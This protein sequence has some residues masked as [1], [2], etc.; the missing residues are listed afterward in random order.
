MFELPL[1]EKI[2]FICVVVIYLAATVIGILQLL[3]GGEKYKRSL[4]P[5][6]SL[7]LTLEAVIL[8]FRAVAI[9]AVPLTGL[10]ESMIVLTIVL[11]LTYLFFS[12]AIQQVWFGSVMVWV[13]LVLVLMAGIVAEPASEPHEIAATPWAIVHGITMILGGASTMFATASSFLYLLGNRRLKHKKV[14]KVIG[15]VPNIEKLERMTLFGIRAGFVLITIGLI[16]GLGLVSVVGTGILKWLMDIKVI[17]IIA[18]WI[19]LGIILIL[20]HLL[21]LKG[22]ARAYLT[23][24]VFIFV[25]FAILGATILGTTQHDF[26]GY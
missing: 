12:I 3:A 24:A 8:I 7:A 17:C 21:A 9:K 6:V 23:M 4:L 19:L 16:S 5:L 14:M 11:G 26:A 13:I 15:R 1:P 18:A 25:L 2:I 22:K 20:N 10:F